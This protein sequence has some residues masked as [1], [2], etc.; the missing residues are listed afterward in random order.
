MRALID[1]L[2]AR[3]E[4]LIIQREVDPRHELA[5]V[6]KAVQQSS[7]SSVLF[8]NV[9]G[10]SLPVATNLYN[11]RQRLCR[12]LGAEPDGFCQRWNGLHDETQAMVG[13]D[14]TVVDRPGDLVDCRISDL[15]Q[16]T[17]HER[18]A[19]PYF[20]S[21]LF[22]AKHPETGAE[23]LSFHR[24]MVVGDSELRVRLGASH[25]LCTYQK[26]AE[27]RGEYLEAAMLIGAEPELFMSGCASLPIDWS[28]MAFA[29]AMKGEPIERYPGK[30]VDLMIPAATQVVIEGRFIPNVRRP[31]GPFGEFL[32]YYVEVGDNTV[33]EVLNVYTQPSPVFHSLLCGSNEDISLLEART[34]AK[35]YRHLS[36]LVPGII[37]VACAPSVMNTSIKINQ[38]YEGHARQVLMAAFAGHLDYNKVCIV[39]DEDVDI[40]DMSEVMWAFVTRGRADTRTMVIP[41]VPGFYRDEHKDHWGRLGLDATMPFGREAEFQR[42]SVPGETTINLADYL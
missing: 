39:V 15:P 28:E 40:F 14:T 42:K 21:A 8:E 5:A 34:A 26:L 30:S 27:E 29:S 37:D 31:E 3:D 33:F 24:A 20:T 22:L 35:T 19:G 25:D 36:Q 11:S 16:I 10:T 13:A 12:M 17:Y 4:L 1:D 41:D 38:L 6:T 23:N 9:R 2:R 18:D 32:G 7:N